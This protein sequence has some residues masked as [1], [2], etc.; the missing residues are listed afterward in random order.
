MNTTTSAIRIESEGTY[1]CI[2]RPG[3]TASGRP[4]ATGF[5]TKIQKDVDT[6]KNEWHISQLIRKI[7]GY[8]KYFS[9]ILQQYPVKM[10]PSVKT[11][12]K[13]CGVF[14]NVSNQDLMMRTYVSNKIRYIGKGQELTEY[15]ATASKQQ[16]FSTHQYL[17]DAIEQLVS[18][19]LVHF[20]IKGNNI[21]MDEKMEVPIL[22]DFGLSFCTADLR[23]ENYRSIFYVYDTYPYWPIETF[24]CNY[25]F[26]VVTYERSKTS[27]IT[28]EDIDM[29]LQG[30]I[31]GTDPEDVPSNYIFR[32]SDSPSLNEWAKHAKTWLLPWKT[33]TWWNL[34]SYLI[35]FHTTW[36][37]YALAVTYLFIVN[38]DSSWPKDDAYRSLLKKIVYS[39]PEK[40][41]S[42]RDTSEEITRCM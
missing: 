7:P 1:G 30:F 28:E 14:K 21:I 5:I 42:L 31:Y 27:T 9:P 13:K 2:F 32:V 11:E 23:P 40:R 25:I 4:T 16:V 3:I 34:Y 24:L 15:V 37:H 19:K 33:K 6:V 36:D 29:L 38:D 8:L 22:I 41:P 35:P 10:R 18:H 12:I 20:D 39:M 17:L 26:Q